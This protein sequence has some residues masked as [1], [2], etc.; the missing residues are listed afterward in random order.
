VVKNKLGVSWQI[1]PEI[2]SQLMGEKAS[3]K[4]V[5]QAF[6]KMKKIDIQT[7]IEASKL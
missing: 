6:M 1:V 7:L 2:L 4:N 5:I 3:Q